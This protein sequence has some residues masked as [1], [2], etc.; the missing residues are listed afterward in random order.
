VKSYGRGGSWSGLMPFSRDGMA[1][2]GC[3]DSV[4]LMGSRDADTRGDGD[5]AAAA[6]AMPRSGLWIAGGFG[7]HG[8]CR[9]SRPRS[10][11][12]NAPL[13]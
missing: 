2:V 12:K 6:A 5:G 7:P 9:Q 4:M 13:N 8:E 10:T 1:L 3:L 11:D